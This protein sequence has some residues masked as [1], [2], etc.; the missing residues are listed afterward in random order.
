MYIHTSHM[1][2]CACV[3]ISLHLC[4]LSAKPY[5]HVCIHMSAIHI[6]VVMRDVCSVIE[7]G[8]IKRFTARKVIT[9]L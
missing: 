4:A 5:A 1:H 2:T 9:S 6:R 8:K 7:L 3:C